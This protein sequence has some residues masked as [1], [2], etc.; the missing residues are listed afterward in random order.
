MPKC[1]YYECYREGVFAFESFIKTLLEPKLDTCVPISCPH[2]G[3]EFYL[4]VIIS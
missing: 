4:K 1:T 3:I 2:D